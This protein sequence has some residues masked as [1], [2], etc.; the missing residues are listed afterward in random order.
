MGLGGKS[1]RNGREIWVFPERKNT[2]LERER[3]GKRKQSVFCVCVVGDREREKEERE[4]ERVTGIVYW[5]VAMNPGDAKQ[6]N[7]RAP[8]LEEKKAR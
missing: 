1:E 6:A 8:R 3:E 7:G 5:C 4:G 2:E